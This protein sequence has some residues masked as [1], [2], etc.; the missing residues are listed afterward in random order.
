M[1]IGLC[2]CSAHSPFIISNTTDINKKESI[3]LTCNHCS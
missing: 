1:I 2:G 3:K